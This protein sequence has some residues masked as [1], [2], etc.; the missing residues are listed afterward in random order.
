MVLRPVDTGHELVL[1]HAILSF[2]RST[3]DGIAAREIRPWIIAEA[4]LFRDDVKTFHVA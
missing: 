3:D 1:G 4:D 2:F